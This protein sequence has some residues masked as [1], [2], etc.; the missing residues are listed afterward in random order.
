MRIG[1]LG[2][3]Q[4]GRMLALAGYRLGMS[5]SFFGQVPHSATAEL[6]QF[7][8]YLGHDFSGLESALSACA[9]VTFETENTPL[10]VVEALE[11][12]VTVAPSSAILAVAQ[13]RLKE[14]KL[15]KTLGIPTPQNVAIES[16]EDLHQAQTKL[17]YPFVLKATTMGYDGK[18]QMVL[19]AAAELAAAWQKLGPR[20]PL[21]AEAWV[22]F[23]REVSL[24]GV[25]NQQGEI[26]FYPLTENHHEEGIL[27]MSLAPACEHHLIQG[28]A[29]D[30][31]RQVMT[32]F[33]YVGVLAIEF[34]ETKTGELLANEMAPRVHNSGHWTQ[35][36]AHTCQFENHLRALVGLPLG[37]TYLV[38]P[39]VMVNLLGEL[40]ALDTPLNQQGHVHLYN[41]EAKSGRKLGHINYTFKTIQ[42]A[43]AWILQ[44][45]QTLPSL[46]ELAKSS[47]G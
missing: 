2:C 8:S 31:M 19:H 29:E 20:A 23:V 47:L 42:E 5:F 38:A 35:N 26:R 17:G 36:G 45:Q 43:Q 14:K 9:A 10:D 1:V 44:N 16:L 4:L 41:K 21:I 40:P 28:L 34:F 46:D 11:S 13:H 15:F 22:P 27:R 25:R 3:G 6:G 7:E 37:D 30:Y 24:I 12:K 39:T 33:N 18:G 32:H